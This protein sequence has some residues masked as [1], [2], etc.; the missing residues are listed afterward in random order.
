VAK[1]GIGKEPEELHGRQ[2]K[3]ISE[4]DGLMVGDLQVAGAGVRG[5]SRLRG[6]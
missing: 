6:D 1:K 2:G 3:P 4:A 5:H